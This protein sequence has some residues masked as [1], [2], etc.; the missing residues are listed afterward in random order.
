VKPWASAGGLFAL[1]ISA[2]FLSVSLEAAPQRAASASAGGTL[3]ERYS[4]A[5]KD[6]EEQRDNE[7]KTRAE[8]DAIAAESRSLQDRLIANA[9]KVQELEAAVESSA[10]ELQRLNETVRNIQ[11]DLLRDRDRVAHLLAVLQRLQADEPPALALKP[12]D[13]LAAARGTMQMG[14]MLPPVYRE[15]AALAKKLKTLGETRIALVKKGDEARIEAANLSD[16]RAALDQL[17]QEKNAEQADAD[18]KLSELHAVTEEVG[19]EASDLKALIDR[20]ASLRAA[21]PASE[22]MKIV[23]AQNGAAGALSRGSLLRP[24]VGSATPG[25]PAGPGRTPGQ[26]GPLGLWFETAGRAEAVAPADSEVVFAGTYQKFGQVLILEIAGGYHLTLAGL[27]RIDVHIGDS[28]L[29]G[30]PVGVLPE[31]RAARL[32]MELRRNGQAVDPAP[33]LSA[34]LRK[35]KGT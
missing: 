15:A 33:W 3:A 22:G 8:R 18:A 1:M 30:E 17:L 34:E 28:V 31:G 10:D 11:S 9:S 19:R 21:G 5:Q 7:D 32:Y 20:V 35:A 25:D 13:S 2:A 24:V 26:N 4:R 12:G 6:F 27:G 29:A 23:T 14:A 16:A